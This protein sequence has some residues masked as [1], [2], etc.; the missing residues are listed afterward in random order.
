M[1]RLLDNHKL[2][3]ERLSLYGVMNQQLL[4]GLPLPVILIDGSP[5]T[6]DQEQQL[7]R[8]SI[9]VKGRSL[10]LYEEIHPRSKLGNQKAQ[11][12]FPMTLQL[13]LAVGWTPS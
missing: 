7:L 11:Q 13:F 1:D 9:P 12:A 4:Q 10:T 5:L 3:Q 8:V 2:R 6:A